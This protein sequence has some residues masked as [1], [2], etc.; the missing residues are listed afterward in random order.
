MSYPSAVLPNRPKYRSEKNNND[1]GGGG[2][3]VNIMH[4]K[5][6]IRGNTYAVNQVR[7]MGSRKIGIRTQEG[8]SPEIMGTDSKVVTGHSSSV[9]C[10]GSG[11]AS[12]YQIFIYLKLEMRLK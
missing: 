1:D 2:G 3:P 7:W 10:A 4:D 6:V 11:S 9:I 12:Q 8:Q 5:R